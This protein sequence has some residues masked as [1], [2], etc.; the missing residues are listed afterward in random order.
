[1]RD[2]ESG[3]RRRLID[4]EGS[5]EGSVATEEG[6]V[7]GTFDYIAPEVRAGRDIS[8][9]SDVYALGLLMQEMGADSRL[10]AR[11]LAA[12]PA[13]RPSAAEVKGALEA[14]LALPARGAVVL[15]LA[16]GG[17]EASGARS[18]RL[19]ARAEDAP[20][21]AAWTRHATGTLS[22]AVVRKL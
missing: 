3:H 17:P 12:D 19:Y 1:M 4:A 21:D 22:R 20:A 15:Q 11:C 10:S 14:A 8:P 16:V 7:R 2:E 9:A 18:F 6:K 13:G 5:V